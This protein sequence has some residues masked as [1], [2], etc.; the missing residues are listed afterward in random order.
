[1]GVEAGQ[2]LLNGQASL[3]TNVRENCPS[4]LSNY[5][6]RFHHLRTR[7][8]I[9]LAKQNFADNLVVR[10]H[11]DVKYELA[12][13]VPPSQES[14]WNGG[15]SQLSE[16]L[17]LAHPNANALIA[18]RKLVVLRTWIEFRIALCGDRAF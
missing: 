2:E 13:G 7:L 12:V 14:D 9:R 3:A 5:T 8:F 4:L 10:A 11:H 16:N 6:F 17:F 18:L 15:M 1:M